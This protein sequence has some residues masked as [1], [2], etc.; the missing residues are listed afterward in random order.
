MVVAEIGARSTQLAFIS[1]G[2]YFIRNFSLGGDTVT[3]AVADELRVDLAA[4]E[5]IKVR[6]LSN[7]S[8]AGATPEA[9]TAVGHAAAHFVDRLHRE[10]VRSTLAFRHHTGAPRPAV[11]HLTG[12][13]ALIPGL[14]AMLAD[15]LAMR[16]V[17]FAPLHNVTLLPPAQAAAEGAGP[18]LAALV[19]LATG[20]RREGWPEF[21]LLPAA[22]RQAQGSS[23]RRFMLLGAAALAVAAPLP[24]AWHCQ[25]VAA[26]AA[27]AVA[28]TE[29]RLGPLRSLAAQNADGLGRIEAANRQIA[30]LRNLM[31]AKSGWIV[32]L[33]DLQGRLPQ[34]GMCGSTNSWWCLHPPPRAAH[35]Q[36]PGAASWWAAA[37]RP[38][39]P[40]GEKQRR[41]LRADAGP[42][43]A[44]Q[45]VAFH[46]GRRKRAFRP[47]AAG[48]PALRLHAR[49]G[50]R[51]AALSRPPH[52]PLAAKPAFDP[53]PAFSGG[54]VCR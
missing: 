29:A 46:C 13:G 37:A 27:R 41:F 52:A 11:V 23:R 22:A 26:A 5:K 48:H 28:G 53:G 33:N 16:V 12:G 45:P 30:A 17:V 49:A 25:R 51:E 4:A 6:A 38:G 43:A 19:G 34:P 31:E 50:S 21:N 24:V 3:E 18:F 36:K 1:T 32:F 14:P 7:A 40:G 2:R 47:R 54:P 20:L 15:K 9:R 44:A 35:P 8:G 39:P 10:I 42:P